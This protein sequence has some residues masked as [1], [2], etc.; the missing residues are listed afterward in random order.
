MNRTRI[1]QLET[2]RRQEWTHPLEYSRDQAHPLQKEKIAQ[3][4]FKGAAAVTGERVKSEEM[5]VSC[6]LWNKYAVL[7]N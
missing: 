5:Q 2:V 1:D 4:K 6:L 7:I 3:S